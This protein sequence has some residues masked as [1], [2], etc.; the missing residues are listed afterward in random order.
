MQ[1]RERLQGAHEWL[2]ETLLDLNPL[3]GAAIMA[4]LAVIAEGLHVRRSRRV[5][6]LAFG[7]SS[8]GAPPNWVRGVAVVRVLALGGL[9]WSLLV[10]Y[11]F[12]PPPKLDDPERDPAQHLLVVWDASPSMFLRDAGP[13]GNQS[14]AER[15]A[16]LVEGILARLDTRRTRVSVVAFYT[17]AKPVVLET[18]DM[19][20]VTN[21][22]R[23]LPLGHAFDTGQTKLQEGVEASLA[24]AKNW[25]RASAAL[26]V[27]SDGDSLPGTPPAALPDSV[28]DCLVL[29][30]GN[31]L[32][33]APIAGRTSRQDRRSL[34]HLAVRLGGVYHDGNTQHLP[35]QVLK[36]LSMGVPELAEGPDLRDKALVVA[37]FSALI[38]ALL[39]LLLHAFGGL[40]PITAPVRPTIGSDLPVPASPTTTRLR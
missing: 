2:D 17:G 13:E 3:L 31:P 21:V 24:F 10:L 38:L 36:G 11:G 35:S 25:P 39:P 34:E 5:E 27:V 16:D 1:V 32:R 12:R 19:A 7:L 8:K 33:G 30:V 15:A 40:R 23:G 9:V 29:G 28:A 6:R 20:V 18:F 4:A 37:A 22:L 14:R 26:L